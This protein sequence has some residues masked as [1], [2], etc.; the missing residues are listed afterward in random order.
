MG[1]MTL[2]PETKMAD[3]DKLIS[4]GNLMVRKVTWLVFTTTSATLIFIPRIWSRLHG[5]DCLYIL[6][7]FSITPVLVHAYTH[8]HTHKNIQQT[9][10]EYLKCFFFMHFLRYKFSFFFVLLCFECSFLRIVLHL[11]F[12][13]LFKYKPT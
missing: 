6:S 11:C 2:V 12:I 7:S 1:M 3:V 4:H 8:T 10:L 9:I 13:C 5:K